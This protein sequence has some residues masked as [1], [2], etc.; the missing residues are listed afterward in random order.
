MTALRSPSPSLPDL[1]L[2]VDSEE[3]RAVPGFE[4]YE[5]SRDFRARS[6]RGWGG[7][8]SAAPKPVTPWSEYGYVT[9]S[10]DTGERV[11]RKIGELV[12]EAWGDGDRARPIK[13]PPIR[14]Q[15]GTEEVAPGILRVRKRGGRPR[16]PVAPGP[17]ADAARPTP[18]V[19]LD[20]DPSLDAELDP[21]IVEWHRAIARRMEASRRRAYDMRPY[22]AAV[23]QAAL[24]IVAILSGL[25]GRSYRHPDGRRV[26]EAT[27][28]GTLVVYGR[29]PS[30]PAEGTIAHVDAAIGRVKAAVIEAPK[31][32]QAE[33]A[34]RN[35][36]R[37]EA[38]Q[39]N[40]K[41]GEGR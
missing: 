38:K 34:R 8:R 20:S 3:W 9:M 18:A 41:T 31:L 33:R 22:V 4:L 36:E 11:V 40:W 32:K 37:L 15:A 26:F 21:L 25:P 35:F 5:V 1:A 12:R 30:P 16:R 27:S 14:R 13:H 19:R 24:P 29:G 39:S 7:R 6:W 17:E 28:E 2:A 23:E 10:T